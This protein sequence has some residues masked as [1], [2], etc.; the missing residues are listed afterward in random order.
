MHKLELVSVYCLWLGTLSIQNSFASWALFWYSLCLL[1]SINDSTKVS[2]HLRSHS[3]NLLPSA[4]PLNPSS[5]ELIHGLI[6][7]RGQHSHNLVT[8]PQSTSVTK[9]SEKWFH[10]DS[11]NLFNIFSY[12]YTQEFLSYLWVINYLVPFCTIHSRWYQ[13][14]KFF[15]H[16]G[17][18]FCEWGN[19]S[20]WG[21]MFTGCMNPLGEPCYTLLMGLFGGSPVRIMYSP[22][23]YLSSIWKCKFF[24]FRRMILGSSTIARSLC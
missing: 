1:E 4:R 7:W 24:L 8:L 13:M 22:L 17:S 15:S 2:L 11:Q 14:V 5:E 3:H 9:S 6:R 19:R 20:L 21:C 12:R 18:R 23:V 16:L 10:K